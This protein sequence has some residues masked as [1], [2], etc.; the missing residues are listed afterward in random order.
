MLD[1]FVKS[2]D[3]RIEKLRFSYQNMDHPQYQNTVHALKSAAKT[4]GADH[5]SALAADLED[6]VKHN[7]ID[8]ISAH[9]GELI[10]SLIVTISG[11]R[12]VMESHE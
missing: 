8:F 5:L 3:M 9:H 2:A 10:D 11:I 7:Q 6:A 4:V 1:E 12:T